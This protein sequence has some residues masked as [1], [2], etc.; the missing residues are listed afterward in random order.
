MDGIPIELITRTW[1]SS[2]PVICD[3]VRAA[4]ATGLHPT[5]LKQGKTIALRKPGRT[6]A[7]M[8]KD[9]RPI[10]ML[11]TLS[12][13][14][15]KVMA[16][17]IASHL[18][19]SS[20]LSSLFF[21]DEQ[22]GFRACRSCDQASAQ[23][24]EKI[25]TAKGCGKVASVAFLDI[26]GAYDTVLP[27]RLIKAMIDLKLPHDVVKWTLSFLTNRST[28]FSVEDVSREFQLSIGLPQGSPLSPVLYAIYNKP[29]IEILKGEGCDVIAYADDLAVIA[30]GQLIEENCVELQRGINW[31]RGKSG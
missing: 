15:E 8:T 17:R 1:T 24:T 14:I 18:E 10:T 4:V 9:Y 27:S 22:Y 13:I 20:V 29:A 31:F 11:V 2:G 19:P 25:R 3:L 12:K 6:Q 7:V 28:T 30:T 23:L 5:I 21:D 26:A 16:A